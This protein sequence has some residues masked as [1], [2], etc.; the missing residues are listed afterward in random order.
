MSSL[1]G[2]FMRDLPYLRQGLVPKEES[3]AEIEKLEY[4]GE[5]NE[6]LTDQD[7][8]D[9]A[10]ALLINN[11]FQGPL[12]L[13]ENGL[14]DLAALY[15]ASAFEKQSGYN[16]TKLNLAENNFTSKAGE[17][18]GSALAANPAYTLEK[19]SF[20]GVCLER[21]GLVRVIEAV[22]L[23]TNIKKLNV[24]VVT[25][26]GLAL[27]ADLLRENTSLEQIKI[28]ETDDHQKY[29]TDAGRS[30]FT[31]MIKTCTV[32][33]KVELKLLLIQ[34]RSLVDNPMDTLRI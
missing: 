25:D 30:A 28:K 7:V 18:V 19:L 33:K 13:Q 22:N 21:I 14:S 4:E 26:E 15:L 34:Q 6:K 32:L 31:E 29:W 27:L 9:L 24:G 17:Y 3:G 11:S 12:E 5:K 2:R 20:K 8:K 23:N 1:I 16:I 10:D